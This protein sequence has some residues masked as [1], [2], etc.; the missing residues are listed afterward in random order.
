LS[1]EGLSMKKYVLR[2]TDEERSALSAVV[3]RRGSAGYERRRAQVLLF[4]DQGD[5]GPGWS[6]ERLSTS[7]GLSVRTIEHLRK[8]AV[9]KGALTSLGRKKR[10]IGPRPRKFTGEEEAHLIALAC[11]EPPDGHA[12][13]SVRL[14]AEHLVVLDVFDSVSRESVRRALKKTNSNLGG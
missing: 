11:S 10:E 13:W 9:E 12:R 1:T 7:F 6:D 2:L 4:C 14:L 8:A 5:S 3:D